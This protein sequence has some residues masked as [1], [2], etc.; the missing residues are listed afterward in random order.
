MR[1]RSFAPA[2]LS[3]VLVLLL[4]GCELHSQR[5]A[6]TAQTQTALH[7]FPSN[8]RL[9]GRIDTRDLRQQSFTNPVSGK[10]FSFETLRDMFVEP[11]QKLRESTGFNPTKDLDAVYFAT[12][13]LAEDKIADLVAV[14]SLDRKRFESFLNEQLPKKIDRTPYHGVTIYRIEGGQDNLYFA[15][16]GESLIIASTRDTRVQ[17]ML[18]RLDGDA[19]S[20]ADD[21]GTVNLIEQVNGGDIWVVATDLETASWRPRDEQDAMASQALRLS[22]AVEKVAVTFDIHNDQ[23]GGLLVMSPQPKV[24]ADDL[25]D[26][27][28]GIIGMMKAQPELKGIPAEFLDEIDVDDVDGT[29]R[30]AAN[31]D[32]QT[33]KDVIQRH[34]IH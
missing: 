5:T 20:L 24:S 30:V 12:E 18:D 15:L 31:V 27:T 16:I 26:L 14:V 1:L 21:S 28:R 33:L 32:E 25:A 23:V 13:G 17:S 22:R 19:A 3:L 11:L 9:V 6:L 34:E 2:G 4:A 29:V 7:V 8:V 10:V